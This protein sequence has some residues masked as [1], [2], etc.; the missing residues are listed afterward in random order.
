MIK[1]YYKMTSSLE[2]LTSHASQTGKD[3]FVSRLYYRNSF[4]HIGHLKTLFDNDTIAKSHNGFCCAI[5][6]DRQ[7]YNR[8]LS[9]TEDFEYLNLRNIKVISVKNNN[10]KIIAYTIH[11]IRSGYIYLYHCDEKI[12]N[13]DRIIKIISNPKIHVQL[14]LN[15]NL[16]LKDPSIGYTTSDEHGTLTISL[17]FDYI[18]KVL[19][20]LLS[21]TDIITTICNDV[22]DIKDSNIS[23]FFD[24]IIKIKYTKIETYHIYN[25]RYSKRGWDINEKN[26]YLLTIKGLKSRYIPVKVLKAFYLHA[27]Q[28]GSIKIQFLGILLSKHLYKNSEKALGVLKPIKVILDNWKLKQTEYVCGSVNSCYST[29]LKHYPLSDV[30]YIDQADYGIDSMHINKG[31]SMKLSYGPILTCTD[32]NLSNYQSP[33]LHGQIELSGKLESRKINWISAP[34]DEQPCSVKFYLYNWF[35][36]GFNSLIDPEITDG[37]IDKSVFN[38][39]DKI[40]QLENLGYFIYDRDLSARNNIHTFI[41][42]SR[43]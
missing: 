21:V 38:D 9:V 39:L 3:N 13:I 5:I 16:D 41:R 10:S 2:V 1:K 18:I 22:S 31:R 12:T 24:K 43:L 25:F 14:R 19:D 4:F 6:D 32:I 35:Y 28:M 26:P 8:F 23:N 40:Y 29:E 15:C 7:D 11:L 37:Y 34:W 20:I 33:V 42:I 27:C 36:T 30:L 17:I